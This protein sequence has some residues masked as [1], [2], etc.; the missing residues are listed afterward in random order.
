MGDDFWYVTGTARA[1]PDIPRLT[2]FFHDHFQ[3]SDNLVKVVF[4]WEDI[5]SP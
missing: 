1:P 4:Q 2:F 5:V 3:G